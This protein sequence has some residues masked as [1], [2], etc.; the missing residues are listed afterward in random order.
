MGNNVHV[1]ACVSNALEKSGRVIVLL[2]A[3]GLYVQLVH[4]CACIV[5]ARHIYVCDYKHLYIHLLDA[6]LH[7]L[8]VIII[9]V[10]TS[11]GIMVVE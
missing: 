9:I 10:S 4:V 6:W 7:N 1:L 3:V 8:E 5:P 11:V 2:A